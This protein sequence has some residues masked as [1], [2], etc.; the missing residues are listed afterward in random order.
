MGFS[1][2]SW[3]IDGG[4]RDLKKICEEFEVFAAESSEDRSI[5]LTSRRKG[6][7]ANL[8]IVG[9]CLMSSFNVLVYL[10]RETP[11]KRWI[12]APVINQSIF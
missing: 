1:G 7:A 11:E 9:S 6:Q 2:I 12:V 4:Q 10:Y 8:A 3:C 5:K